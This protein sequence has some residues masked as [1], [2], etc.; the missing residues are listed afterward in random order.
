MTTL[1]EAIKLQHDAAEAHP[2]TTLL[3]SGNIDSNIYADLLYNQTLIYQAIENRLSAEFEY[4]WLPA[5]RRQELMREDLTELSSISLT[6]FPSTL[7]AISRVTTVDSRSLHAHLYVNHLAD[8]YGGQ[9]LKRSLPGSCKRYEYKD[10]AASIEAIRSVLDNDLC[11]EAVVAFS[12]ALELL[13]DVA[14][15]YNISS[16]D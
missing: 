15:K 4:E 3:L 14:R 8:M 10:R 9:I 6:I 2:L 16:S 13:N 7:N 5:V 1:R 11:D 12:H